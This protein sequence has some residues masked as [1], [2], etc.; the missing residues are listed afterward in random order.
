MLRY[1]VSRLVELIP[2]FFLCLLLIFLIV[3]AAPGDPV[4][5][6]Y[7]QHITTGE[8]LQRL[9]AQ[10]GLDRPVAARFLVYLGGLAR[11]DLGRSITTGH[12]VGQVIASRIG[13]T[14]LL[15]MS[16]TV[17]AVG[18]GV[19]L[20]AVAARRPNSL[21]DSALMVL[22]LVGYSIPT[23]LLGLLLIM[24]FSLAFPLFPTFGMTTLGGNYAGLRQILDVL[25]HLILPAIV[26]AVWYLAVYARI[27][28]VSLIGALREPYIGTARAKGL[29]EWTVT[30]RHA[31]R[32]ALLPVLTNLGLQLGSMVTGAIVTE[33]LFAWPGIGYLSYTALLQRDYPVLVG[34]FVISSICVL[35]ANLLTDL[36]YALCDPRIRL[37]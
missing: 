36:A 23:F 22:T 34:I 24:I 33:T 29:S 12:P 17:L 32:N 3:H 10:Y 35:A 18:L 4:L 13:P 7:G 27:T 6:L 28:R 1:A 5:Y 14:V 19:L 15:M 9:R 11:G 2:V 26:V 37:Q 20:G 16:A 25:H 30:F 21:T 31:L 8:D